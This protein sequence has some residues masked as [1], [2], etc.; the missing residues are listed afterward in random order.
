MSGVSSKEKVYICE[1]AG[2]GGSA[3]VTFVDRGKWWEK[4]CSGCRFRP[5]G[6]YPWIDNPDPERAKEV[7]Q[8]VEK[9]DD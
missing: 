1:V 9:I 2:R 5:R 6:G 4:T 3:R 7:V 8:C